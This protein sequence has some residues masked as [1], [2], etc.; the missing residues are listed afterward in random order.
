MNL[1][2]FIFNAPFQSSCDLCA[3]RR[4]TILGQESPFGATAA[5]GWS[6]ACGET[7][8]MQVNT[9][10]EMLGMRT[11]RYWGQN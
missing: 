2:A 6:A 9:P 3:K 1:G 8:S 10:L 4:H 11:S 5:S 7:C